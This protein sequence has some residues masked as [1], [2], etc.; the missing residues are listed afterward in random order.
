M[1]DKN[2]Q[3]LAL[4]PEALP[5]TTK[6]VPVPVD[7]ASVEQRVDPFDVK[8]AVVDGKVLAIDYEK[9]IRDFGTRRISPEL[10]GRFEKLT[11]HKPHIFL[12]RGMFFSHRDLERILDRYEQG[13]SFFLY[14][15]RGPS[16]ESMHLG[17]MIPFMFT[18][19]DVPIVFH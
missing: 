10:L 4:K 5:T 12:R 3:P 19:Y 1:A 13:K 8:G 17:H 14:T 16:S 11:G 15:G 7:G 6:D 18:K 2:A 9:L